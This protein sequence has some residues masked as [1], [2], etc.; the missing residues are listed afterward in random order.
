MWVLVSMT[1]LRFECLEIFTFWFHLLLDLVVLQQPLLNK[2][3][4]SCL[5]IMLSRYE[6]HKL[7]LHDHL[8]TEPAILENLLSSVKESVVTALLKDLTVLNYVTVALRENRP[9]KCPVAIWLNVWEVLRS[10]SKK[11]SLLML[12]LWI[13]RVSK[14]VWSKY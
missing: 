10:G 3:W 1:S 2:T 7:I 13:A 14:V 12:K 9:D 8:Q 4:W 5:D 11:T 6:E